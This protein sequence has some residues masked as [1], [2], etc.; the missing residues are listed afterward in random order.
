MSEHY[1]VPEYDWDDSDAV[2]GNYLGPVNPVNRS[3]AAANESLSS[4]R[5]IRSAGR[6]RIGNVIAGERDGIGIYLYS[7]SSGIVIEGNLIGTNAEGTEGLEINFG[8]SGGIEV[9]KRDRLHHR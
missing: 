8:G 1:R 9:E 6:S 4:H 5:A 2:E 7:G 3:P